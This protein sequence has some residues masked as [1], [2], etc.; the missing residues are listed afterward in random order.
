M[1]LSAPLCAT[2]VPP[3]SE[4]EAD[5]LELELSRRLSIVFQHLD[6]MADQQS[7]SRVQALSYVDVQVREKIS[8]L[9]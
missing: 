3:G 1:P 6:I 8:L 2:Q 5:H 4:V 9:D 7:Q